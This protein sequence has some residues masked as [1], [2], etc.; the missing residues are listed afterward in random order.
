MIMIVMGNKN[1]AMFKWENTDF[2][3]DVGFQD[4]VIIKNDII[5]CI[6]YCDSKFNVLC[7]YIFLKK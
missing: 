3:W 1:A 5:Y 4:M 2:N 7:L 6:Y